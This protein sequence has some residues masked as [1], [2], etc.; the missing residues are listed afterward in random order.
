MNNLLKNLLTMWGIYYLIAGL[1]S[2]LHLP[3]FLNLIQYEE[4]PFKTAAN[5]I[6]FVSLGIIYVHSAIRRKA[7]PFTAFIAGITAIGLSVVTFNFLNE[8][9]N[10]LAFQIDATLELLAGI[11]LIIMSLISTE[12]RIQ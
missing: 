12:R 8:I 4:G 7:M 5:G 10:P 9:G 3:S 2:V 6:L 11:C 1:W